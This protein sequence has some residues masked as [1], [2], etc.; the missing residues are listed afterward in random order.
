MAITL[1]A[2]HAHRLAVPV[3]LQG[4]HLLEP[5]LGQAS[6]AQSNVSHHPSHHPARLCHPQ[7]YLLARASFNLAELFLFG[8]TKQTSGVMKHFKEQCIFDRSESMAQQLTGCCFLHEVNVCNV[9]NL[10]WFEAYLAA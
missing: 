7:P 6:E 3:K 4:R 1:S 8:S 10:W 9:Q 2:D 5:A